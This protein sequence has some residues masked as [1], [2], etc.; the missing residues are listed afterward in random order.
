MGY[1]ET[2][3]PYGKQHGRILGALN[4]LNSKYTQLIADNSW[5]KPRNESLRALLL[6]VERIFNSTPRTCEF[7]GDV[8]SYVPLSAMQL[9][10]MKTKLV[11]PPPGIFK[12]FFRRKIYIVKN[13]GSV[14]NICVMSFGQEG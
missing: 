8:N 6:E 11:M 2:K 9:L 1:L 4:L 5:R 12:E 3:S 7:I 14:S 13:N 10:T